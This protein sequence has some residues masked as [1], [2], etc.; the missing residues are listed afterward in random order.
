MKAARVMIK[1]LVDMNEHEQADFW[2]FAR[3]QLA[4]GGTVVLGQT[5][6]PICGEELGEAFEYRKEG[7]GRVGVIMNLCDQC[8]K[9]YVNATS[10]HQSINAG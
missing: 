3:E 5:R 4:R 1:P 9:K 8:W 7:S 10:K 6:C 2:Q